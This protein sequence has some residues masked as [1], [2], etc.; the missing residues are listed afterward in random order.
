MS[1]SHD[2][3]YTER[4]I[5]HGT[6]LTVDILEHDLLWANLTS[7]ISVECRCFSPLILHIRLLYKMDINFS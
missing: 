5:V 2:I 3:F 6:F 1:M 7:V 4:L